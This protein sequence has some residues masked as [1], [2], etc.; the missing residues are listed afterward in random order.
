MRCRTLG[1][2]CWR[3]SF[4][5]GS[6][7]PR[8]PH[9]NTVA[10]E[11]TQLR[12]PSILFFLL[13]PVP[14]GPI[15]PLVVQDGGVSVLREAPSDFVTKINSESTDRVT[16]SPESTRNEN[17]M[18]Q[19]VRGERLNRVRRFGPHPRLSRSSR[20]Q[21]SCVNAPRRHP[22]V[23]VPAFC[24]FLS[25]SLCV[26]LSVLLCF[27][28]V[29]HCFCFCCCCCDGSGCACGYSFR[30]LLWFRVWSG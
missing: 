14:W 26:C 4:R 13:S 12:S 9:M 5:L 11:L 21:V 18:C 23:S 10:R 30:L 25:L 27:G 19:H 15:A 2:L 6:V 22:S 16:K 7:S 1:C 17:M 29:L 20:P 24:K 8:Q 3:D 28:C